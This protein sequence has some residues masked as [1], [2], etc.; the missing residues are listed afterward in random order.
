MET[1]LDEGAPPTEP[2]PRLA[3]TLAE[4]RRRR[5]RRIAVSAAVVAVA[6][7]GGGTAWALLHDDGAG[8]GP[9]VGTL[10]G[11]E[12][13]DGGK[14]STTTA[15]GTPPAGG[16]APTLAAKPRW[17]SAIQGRPKQFG[18]VNDPPPATAGGI[19]DGFY[20]WSDFDGWHLWLVGGGDADR[21]TITADDEI[22]RA[23]PTDPSATIERLGNTLTFSRGGA[24]GEV[25]G[26][27]FSPGFY[28][29]TLIVS[30]QGDLRVHIG[31]RRSRVSQ[32]YGIQF[33][34]ASR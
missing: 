21:V 28:S 31:N 30:V 20:L 23:D 6:L 10:I 9:Q 33:S 12:A 19:E 25:V 1:Q 17:P 22:R 8:G 18:K 16:T 3:R 32:Y 24:D 29:K 34:A 4:Q 7:L 14:K 15:A 26:M 11:S 5:R 27:D 2:G 13:A